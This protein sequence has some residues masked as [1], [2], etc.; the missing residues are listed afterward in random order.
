MPMHSAPAACALA[1]SLLV[2]AP[3]LAA[4]DAVEGLYAPGEVVVRF[5]Q[6]PGEGLV[7]AV[8]GALSP[9]ATWRAMR[10][11]PHAKDQPGTPHPLSYYRIYFVEQDADVRGLAAMIAQHP[12]V[13]VAT[14]NG[15]PTPAFTP[16]DPLWPQQWAHGKINTAGA[17]DFETG[18]TSIVVGVIDTGVV[19]NHE[20][21]I[22]HVWINPGEIPGNGIDDDANGF[23]DDTFGWNFASNN[24]NVSDVYSH[25]TQVSGIVGAKVNNGVG[26]A[27]IGNFTLLTSKWWHLSGTDATVAESVFYAVD[28][29][30]HVLNMSLG[31]QCPLPLTEAACNYATVHGVVNVA[32]AGNAFGAVGW[33]AKYPNVMAISAVTIND[34][35]ADFSNF[36]PEIDVAAPSPDI[37]TT[38]SFG[39]TS[40]D[41]AFGGTSAASPHVAGLAALVLSVDPTLSPEEVRALINENATDLGAPGFD[42]LFGHG[43]INVAA[44]IRA[45]AAQCAADC[46]GDGQANVFDFLCFQGLVTNN[47]PK[48]DCTGDGEVNIFDWLCF[49]GLVSKGCP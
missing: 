2:A 4:D 22:G 35:K 46:N 31:C 23:I 36:G 44:T 24:S 18:D 38:G 8:G 10:H 26:V 13:D 1:A 7:K 25:G 15:L 29:G 42:N 14:V 30:A 12:A 37:L 33:P 6:P 9:D 41:S 27:G 45:I 20:D 19:T 5:H 49:Q 3:A 11:A 16:D 28:N 32:A 39:A 43:R 17:W 40:Y 21:L 34:V 48:A 47:D